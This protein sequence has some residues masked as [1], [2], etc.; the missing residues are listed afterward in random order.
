MTAETIGFYLGVKVGDPYDAEQLR[1]AF[2]KLWD[3]GLFEDLRL[4]KEA[5]PG[6]VR[7]VAVVVERPRV[8]DLEF[9][10]NKKLTTSQLK[11]KLKEGKVEIRVGAPLSLPRRLEGEGR[12]RSTPTAPRGSA[13]SAVDAILE[14]M[15]ENERRV[16]FLVDEGDKIKIES[17][18]FTGN[19][20][21]LERPPAARDEEDAGRRTSTSSG[22]R[23]TSTT[24]R[25]T[26]R[27]SS[28]SRRS[29]RTPGYKDVVVKDPV[30]ETFVVNPKE[31]R[32]DKIKRRARITDPD[33]RRGALLL[34]RRED[35]GSDGLPGRSPP[36]LLR[37]AARASP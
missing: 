37:L 4:E 8:G 17:I 10:G 23:R 18:D 3:S 5:A 30:I 22:T 15:G 29:T 21:L 2:P 31:T 28:R 19:T 32:R 35:R 9:R 20:R 16:V 14:P 6:G 26:R 13:R 33:R 1:R 27:T 12:P 7:I 36:A 11:D 34:R 25:T 24:R